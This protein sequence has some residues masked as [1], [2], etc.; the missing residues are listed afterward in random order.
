MV[1][2]LL[3]VDLTR[4]RR[5]GEIDA[6]G[7]QRQRTRLSS[8]PRSTLQQRRSLRCDGAALN[9]VAAV[10]RAAAAAAAT[11]SVAVIEGRSLSHSNIS[12]VIIV[13]IMPHSHSAQLCLSVLGRKKKERKQG[14]SPFRLCIG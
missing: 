10:V 2:R 3:L 1:V 14:G 7:G 4:L 13:T 12:I 11:N 9:R 5:S 6:N 8:P